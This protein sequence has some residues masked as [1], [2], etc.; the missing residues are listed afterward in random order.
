MRYVLEGE[1]SGYH[2]G[3]RR[4]VHCTVIPKYIADQIKEQQLH[5]ISYT[6]GTSL[7]LSVREAKPRERITEI[8]GYDSLIR[9]CLH[10]KVSSVS[11]LVAKRE[12]TA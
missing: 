10:Y 8:H 1:W 6:D 2:S 3:Q 4:V 9:D 7:D 11:E 12:R 5:Y